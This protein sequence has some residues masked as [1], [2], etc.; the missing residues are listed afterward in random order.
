M[1]TANQY[2]IDLGNILSTVS[3]I[4]SAKATNALN[5]YKLQKAA[6]EENQRLREKAAEEK[7]MKDPT[8]AVAASIKQATDWENLN[9]AKRENTINAIKQTTSD[10]VVELTKISNIQDPSQQQVELTNYIKSLPP[11]VQK[12]VAQKYGDESG[13][14]TVQS[15][16]RALNDAMVTYKGAEGIEKE[17]LAAVKAKADLENFKKKEE[18]LQNNKKELKRIPQAKAPGSEKTKTP[19]LT[20]KDKLVK[21]LMAKY[22]GMSEA[23]ARVF[24]Y[25]NKSKK[26]S[27]GPMGD[28]NTSS[29][30]NL[31]AG[32]TATPKAN[33]YDPKNV[34][35]Y[36][37]DKNGNKV[38]KMKD[39][40]VIRVK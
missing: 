5:E 39:G 25:Q 4:K 13:N 32:G 10:T 11:E 15:I 30:K 1:E 40:T 14:I 17:N 21:A 16:P 6:E 28:I 38:A 8:N 24:I 22:P 35:Q 33:T 36:G 19:K 29:E 9:K 26:T 37:V 20:D 23:E 12:Q 18:V 7:F 31:P 27:T 34:V 2:G 3:T